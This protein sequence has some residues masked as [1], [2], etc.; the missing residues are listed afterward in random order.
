MSEERDKCK[1]SII[2]RIC[3]TSQKEWRLWL[4]ENHLIKDSVWLV[5]HKKSSSAPTISWSETVDEALCFGWIDGVKK[6][7]DKDKYTQYFCKRKARSTW[8]KINKEKVKY[9]V[10]QGLMRDA[11]F[12]SIAIAKDNG[13]WTILD[14]VEELVVP[15][16]LAHALASRDGANEY[17]EGLSKSGRKI[18]MQWVVLARRPETRQKRI[19]E[20]AENARTR[21]KPRQFR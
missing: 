11:G 12:Q 20:I 14:E 3:P 8:S 2:D 7:I 16:D 21:K 1:N 15:E 18:L 19:I 10:N 13:S 17:F 4:E 6:S 5:L 9:L